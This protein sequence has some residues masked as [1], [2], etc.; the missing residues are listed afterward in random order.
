MLVELQ[1]AAQGGHARLDR[2]AIAGGQVVS[3]AERREQLGEGLQ[4]LPGI[5]VAGDGHDPGPG[6]AEADESLEDDLV[7]AGID[8][9]VLVDVAGDEDGV[10]G[11]LTSG[12]DQQ[13]EGG[14]GLLIA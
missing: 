13:V 5:V 10:D 1:V 7:G 11:R 14:D 9:L 6:V 2:G 12:I 4:A 8:G 3:H